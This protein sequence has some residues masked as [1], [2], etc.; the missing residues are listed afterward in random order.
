MTDRSAIP[1]A[2]RPPL[3]RRLAIVAI[4]LLV[5]ILCQF[6]RSSLAVVVPALV[7]EVPLSARELGFITS[8]FFV[9]MAAM[10]I[11]A[12][13]MF[14][15]F[16]VRRIACAAMA[17]AVIGGIV[18]AR[19]EGFWDFLIGQLLFGV[20]MA[21]LFIGSIMVVGRWWGGERLASLAAIVMSLSYI[22]TLSATAPLAHAI[23]WVGWRWSLLAPTLVLGVATA[24]FFFVVRDAP[25]GH[26]WWGQRRQETLPEILAGVAEVLRHPAIPGL[27]AASFIGYSCGY[28]LRGLW[29]G[30]Y[31]LDVQRL[32]AIA[33][34][35]ILFLATAMGTL[36]L[37]VSGQLTTRIGSPRPVILGFAGLTALGLAAMAA[38]AQPGMTLL[39][40]AFLAVSLLSAF[41]PAVM[42]QAQSS[43]PERLRGRSLTM[44]NFAVFAGV[45]LNQL[46]TGF[47]IDFFPTDAAG[48]H[49]E[50]AY[51]A[52]FAY[53]AAFVAAGTVVYALFGK[54][55][56]KDEDVG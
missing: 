49:S 21:P 17:L 54:M 45:G 8:T 32:D 11:P 1:A 48:G 28:A 6:L 24:L 47:L 19:G 38:I 39:L 18:F 25:P 53:L 15:R 29:M 13:M 46:I 40:A 34:G 30:P 14:D 22:G 5:L 23:E 33:R 41:F 12:G 51:R 43:F 56:R 9:F 16:G 42:G 20:G 2:S 44:I 31:L 36:G 10:Q 37:F 55:A 3:A 35:D 7:R 52:M 26:A 27:F 50:E 4:V